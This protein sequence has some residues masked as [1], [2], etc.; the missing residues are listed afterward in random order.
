M[1][2]SWKGEKML[3]DIVRKKEINEKHR[4]ASNEVIIIPKEVFIEEYDINKEELMHLFYT[5]V[6]YI[7]GYCFKSEKDQFLQ[8]D[9]DIIENIYNE[10]VKLEEN[11]EDNRAVAII[12]YGAIFVN[13]NDKNSEKHFMVNYL[14]AKKEDFNESYS[15]I[16]E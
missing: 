7:F 3:V 1:I 12:L 6:N 13:K 11:E 9:K 15:L 2:K 4:I 8:L 10:I 14:V 16:G 5:T